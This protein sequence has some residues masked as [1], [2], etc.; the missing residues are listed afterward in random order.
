VKSHVRSLM[1]KLDVNARM[2]AVVAAARRG[3]IRSCQRS[4][5]YPVHHVAT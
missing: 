1:N 4:Q 3:L 5:P 2:E